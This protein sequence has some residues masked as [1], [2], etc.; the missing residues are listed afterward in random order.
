[1]NVTLKEGISLHYEYYFKCRT[2]SCNGVFLYCSAAIF[3]SVKDLNTSATGNCSADSDA[4]H[5]DLH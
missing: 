5:L 4:S 2:F 1:M 3:T